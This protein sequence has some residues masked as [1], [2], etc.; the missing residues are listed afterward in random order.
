MAHESV[1]KNIYWWRF[2]TLPI[3]IDYFPR[4]T[5]LPCWDF[6]NYYLW[7]WIFISF[8]WEW[9]R[10]HAIYIDTDQQVETALSLYTALR[11][12]P[13]ES[14]KWEGSSAMQGVCQVS[15]VWLCF[16]Q[17]VPTTGSSAPICVR[18][19]IST[20]SSSTSAFSKYQTVLDFL[21][22]RCEI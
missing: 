18:A 5:S 19:L 16:T 9:T 13:L 15:S 4:Q 17:K 12:W 7:S 10:A 20:S 8:S 22:S 3:N 11:H 2:H 6:P 14:S 21:S 1:L